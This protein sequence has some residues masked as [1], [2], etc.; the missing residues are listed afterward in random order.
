[1]KPNQK[2]KFIL[3]GKEST[4]EYVKDYNEDG[5]RIIVLCDEDNRQYCVDKPEKKSRKK[6]S[7]KVAAPKDESEGV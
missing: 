2:I 3:N 7:N 1:M 4:G 6:A 5:S